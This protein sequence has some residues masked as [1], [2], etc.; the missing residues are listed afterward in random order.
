MKIKYVVCGGAWCFWNGT[1]TRISEA[2]EGGEHGEEPERQKR[3]T[4]KGATT[5][6]R[7]LISRRPH[8]A[9]VSRPRPRV[10]LCSIISGLDGMHAYACVPFVMVRHT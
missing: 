3:V 5:D 2:G 4:R 6:V 10:I 9:T 8:N 7:T 1:R